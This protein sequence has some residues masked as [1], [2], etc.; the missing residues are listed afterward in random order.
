MNLNDFLSIN[1]SERLTIISKEVG[2]IFD[3][4]FNNIEE[5]VIHDQNLIL[6]LDKEIISFDA[7]DYDHIRVFI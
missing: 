1:K 2:N 6:Y 7:Y 3:G 5:L 4:W